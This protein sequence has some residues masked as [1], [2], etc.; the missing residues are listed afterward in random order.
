[1]DADVVIRARLA[2]A[3]GASLSGREVDLIHPD[4]RR[5]HALTGADGNA[6]FPLGRASHAG[7]I[8]L[9]LRFDGGPNGIAVLSLP[10][11]SIASTRL[12][13]Q[14][15][16]GV[17][18]MPVTSEGTLLDIAG[19]SVVEQAVTVT[20]EDVALRAFTDDEG[21]YHATVP[22]SALRRTGRVTATVE[23]AGSLDGAYR[24]SRAT[25]ELH[26]VDGVKTVLETDAILVQRPRIEGRLVTLLGAPILGHDVHVFVEDA[27]ATAVTKNDGTFS[28]VPPLRRDHELGPLRIRVETP[29]TSTLANSSYEATLFL[30]DEG[31]LRAAPPAALLLGEG[32]R[33]P[34]SLTDSRGRPA[35]AS[36]VDVLVDGSEAQARIEGLTL[37]V[38]LPDGI[39][40]GQHALLVRV[41][42]AT[43]EAGPVA[44]V[45]AVQQPAQLI[46]DGIELLNPGAPG[47][48]RVHLKS[49][50]EPLRNAHIL[51]RG[52]T[53]V[54]L[55][56]TT[57][58]SGAAVIPIPKADLGSVELEVVFPGGDAVA[59][60][61]LLARISTTPAS[62]TTA[63]SVWPLIIGAMVIAAGGA[64]F[65]ILRSRRV[66]AA[67]VLRRAARRLRSS[68]PDVKAMYEAY[69]SLLPLAGIAEHDDATLTF[70][71]LLSRF[72]EK[73]YEEDAR[74]LTE[75]FD[76]AVYSPQLLERETLWQAGDALARLSRHLSSRPPASGVAR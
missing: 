49:D 67:T 23:Y 16:E 50:G 28:V 22:Q 70:G 31:I 33:I 59:R 43:V 76:R 42:S 62:A 5:V 35:T 75:A 3:A 24:S 74:V 11:V 36:S 47:A 37:H 13:L 1:L 44:G 14:V 32:L 68:H 58:E 2:D 12:T 26:V 71:S 40:P 7:E 17:R 64:V 45:V 10:L 55:N 15:G 51:V 73:G 4:G 9:K 34:F 41:N 30:K 38:E 27:V 66:T 52:A 18:G 48:V 8:L 6:S 20:I 69:V 56:V 54:L 25:A 39:E 21:K 61:T 72:V 60:T 46:L 29:A 19:R 53:S 65:G 57:D 63:W